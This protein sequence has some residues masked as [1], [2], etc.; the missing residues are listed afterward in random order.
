MLRSDFT[1][2]HKITIEHDN[3]AS[4]L[5]DLFFNFPSGVVSGKGETL[6][7]IMFE[8]ERRSI[9]SVCSNKIREFFFVSLNFPTKKFSAV[10]TC[11][12]YLF[13]GAF[14]YF[15]L[16]PYTTDLV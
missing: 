8:G 6:P 10:L 4:S 9:I 1:L 11:M 12:T 5:I 13:S 14:P 7:F 3:V 15:R 2:D 16:C